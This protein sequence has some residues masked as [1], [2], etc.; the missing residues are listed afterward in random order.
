[1][2]KNKKN[3]LNAHH[4]A[5]YCVCLV[6]ALWVWGRFYQAYINLLAL[7]LGTGA[8]RDTNR[9]GFVREVYPDLTSPRAQYHFAL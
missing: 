3:K 5:K 8:I 1:M 9:A 6:K 2:I 4:V 7:Y